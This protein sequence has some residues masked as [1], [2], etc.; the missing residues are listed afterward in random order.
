MLQRLYKKVTVLGHKDHIVTFEKTMDQIDTKKL[1]GTKLKLCK[2]FR[3]PK[4]SLALKETTCC[5]N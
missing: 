2:I 4:Y 5:R 1:L 3:Y